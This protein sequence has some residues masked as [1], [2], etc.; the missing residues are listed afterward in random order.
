MIVRGI[1][2]VKGIYL[3][4]TPV[5]AVYRGSNRVYGGHVVHF[6]QRLEPIMTTSMS[7]KITQISEGLYRIRG[8]VSSSFSNIN[9]VANENMLDV[10]E[11]HTYLSIV[12]VVRNDNTTVPTGR[13]YVDSRGTM[14]T[15]SGVDGNA[16][17]VA[18]QSIAEPRTSHARIQMVTNATYDA[19]LYCMFFDI[20]E[21]F[22]D[23][24]ELTPKTVDEFKAMFPDDY[25]KYTP[26]PYD[27]YI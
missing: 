25:Y 1:D 26:E 21:M 22:R 9:S 4:D 20:T 10:T 3:G 24:P 27:V 15:G 5:R 13:F 23:C 19:D 16:F 6:R 17:I 12:N 7:G 18:K 14:A 11:G 2:T 8:T